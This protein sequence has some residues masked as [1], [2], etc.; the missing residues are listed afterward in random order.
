MWLTLHL[1]CEYSSLTETLDPQLKSNASSLL[2]HPPLEPP[3]Y[4]LKY[5]LSMLYCAVMPCSYH[6][7]EK[8]TISEAINIWVSILNS[9]I[10]KKFNLIVYLQHIVLQYYDTVYSAILHVFKECCHHAVANSRF[11]FWVAEKVFSDTRDSKP[12]LLMR[13]FNCQVRRL[14]NYLLHYALKRKIKK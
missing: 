14:I 1:Q 4:P 10:K 3:L 11:E 9:E 6:Y 13:K 7:I 5:P 8:M 2:K 12:F